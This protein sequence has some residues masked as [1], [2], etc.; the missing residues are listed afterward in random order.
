MIKIIEGNLEEGNFSVEV[1]SRKLA[2]S[3][4]QLNR[5]VK[6]ISGFTTIQF[7]QNYRLRRSKDLLKI[8]SNNITDVCFKI[9]FNNPAY[10]TKCFREQFGITPKEFRSRYI[11]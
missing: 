9:G 3:I 1:L 4:S 8:E 5:K 11:K 6:A 2:L 10:F 7:I